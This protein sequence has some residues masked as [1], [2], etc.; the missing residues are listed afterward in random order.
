M[1]TWQSTRQLFL[2]ELRG[3]LTGA[4]VTAVFFG[5]M[6]V[7]FLPLLGTFFDSYG[8]KVELWHWAGDFVFL[9]VIPSLG[10]TMNFAAL[11]YWKNDTYSNKL[12]YWRTLPISLNSIV[13]ARM[14]LLVVILILMSLFYFS[15]EYVL[16]KQMQDMMGFSQYLNFVL[17]WVGYALLMGSTY[18][19][20]ELSSNGKTY[21]M[22]CWA[23]FLV[24]GALLLILGLLDIKPLNLSLKWAIE[25]NWTGSLVMAAA[26]LLSLFTM[27]HLLRKRLE[28]R[29]ILD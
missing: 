21:F 15:L 2:H 23:Y 5:Y 18:M 9:T 26:G 29:S 7:V 17:F 4:L 6:G 13:F 12:A 3:S 16:L 10:F 27:G 1:T 20:W 25:Y 8:Q 28:V 11:R 22:I 19:Y 14:A 24:Y